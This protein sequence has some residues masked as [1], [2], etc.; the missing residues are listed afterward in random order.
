[1]SDYRGDRAGAARVLIV[2]DEVLMAM[3]LAMELQN[4][5]YEVADRLPSGEEA[6]QFMRANPADVVIMD[7][8]LTGEMDGVEAA[9]QIREFSEAPIVFMT[10][11]SDREHD[12]ALAQ[13]R[14]AG[15]L[16]KPVS[17][18]RLRDLLDRVTDTDSGQQV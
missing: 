18:S 14:P 15:F 6:V 1:M 2:E 4:A 17:F 12:P 11:Y 8:R 7:I 5:G 16:I 10:G 3:S 13:A 9:V